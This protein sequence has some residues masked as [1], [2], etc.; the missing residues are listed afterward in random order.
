[1]YI[2]KY[3][4]KNL[5][6]NEIAILNPLISCMLS[7]AIIIIMYY[8][9]MPFLWF[10][11]NTMISMGAPAATTLFY[12]KMARWG[13]YIFAIAAMVILLATVWKRTH[14]TGIQKLY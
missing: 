13:F 1:M 7:L 12:M 10:I 3:K 9:F 14:D 5:F 4:N 2:N 6:K 11:G 8:M